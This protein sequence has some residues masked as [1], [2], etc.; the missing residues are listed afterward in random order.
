VTSELKVEFAAKFS[1]T[2]P[3]S[4]AEEVSKSAGGFILIGKPARASQKIVI[5]LLRNWHLTT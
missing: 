5:G 3:I 1:R 2:S 4:N